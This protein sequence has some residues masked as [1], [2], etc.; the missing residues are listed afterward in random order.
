MHVP[1]PENPNPY[2]RTKFIGAEK[3][4]SSIAY[5][6][7]RARR[8]EEANVGEA[9]AAVVLPLTLSRTLVHE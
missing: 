7:G 1:D 2:L 9:Y 4:A 3:T 8:S 6:I 5:S